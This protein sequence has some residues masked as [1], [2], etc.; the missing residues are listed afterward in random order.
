L[1]FNIFQIF[2]SY[3]QD[4]P[5]CMVHVLYMY[6]TVRSNNN[7]NFSPWQF[8]VASSY[9]SLSC[10]LLKNESILKPQVTLELWRRVL[11][12]R[13]KYVNVNSKIIQHFGWLLYTIYHPVLPPFTKISTCIQ[14]GMFKMN[15]CSCCRDTSFY[16]TWISCMIS[17]LFFTPLQKVFW[18][19][20]KEW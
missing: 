11:Y 3:L 18:L 9:T 10:I 20:S 12:H 8:L 7:S 6:C 4:W 13:D 16:T 1:N 14:L 5:T 19:S 17:C 2:P 15:V